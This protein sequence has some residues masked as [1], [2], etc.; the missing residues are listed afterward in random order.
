MATFEVD[1]IFCCPC[2]V[3]SVFNL[4]FRNLRKILNF[5]ILFIEETEERCLTLTIFHVKEPCLLLVLFRKLLKF[6]PR[7][8]VS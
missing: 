1:S 3:T 7:F 2:F 6:F 5:P 4:R 8:N